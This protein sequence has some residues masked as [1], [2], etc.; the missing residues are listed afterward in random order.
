MLNRRTALGL[1]GLAG[2][3]AAMTF[4]LPHFLGPS[5]AADGKNA[6]TLI[7]DEA[8]L[9]AGT[10]V[11]TFAS[12]CFWCTEADFDKVE[13]VVRTISGYIGGH[14]KNPT[15]RQVTSGGTGHLEAVAIYYNPQ[16]VTYEKLLDRYWR[17]VDFTDG[18]GQFCDRG[19]SYAPAIFV[20][21]QDQRKAAA[22]SKKAIEAAFSQDVVV[23][24]R[25]ATEFTPAED[26]HQN[27]YRT[28]PLRYYSYRTGCGRD[29]RLK[30]LWATR[31]SQS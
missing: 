18:G 20:H 3:A 2:L 11:A 9:P 17:T 30:S 14:T 4:G 16:I 15:Y 27:F 22:A 25:Q 7:S 5:I 26:Y 29:A 23:P 10:K 6:T 28:N 24:I 1:M 31:K 8:K 13:G 19:S 12:G 21:S